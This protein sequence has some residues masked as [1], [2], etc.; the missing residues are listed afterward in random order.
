MAGLLEN[1]LG[2]RVSAAKGAQTQGLLAQDQQ[3]PVG[4]DLSHGIIGGLI[5]HRAQQAQ[6][7]QAQNSASQ[8]R[9]QATA[10]AKQL[11]PDNQQLQLLAAAKPD[12]FFSTLAE[13]LKPQ[14]ASAGSTI[15]NPIAG[16]FTAP[17]QD[18]PSK[19]QLFNTGNG[20]IVS[21]DPETNAATP[22]Y[23]RDLAP[24]PGYRL[25]PDG[26]MAFIPGGPADPRTAGGL[27]TAKRAPPRPA[28]ARPT[29]TGL[30]PGY[31]PR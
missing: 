17:V 29:I 20:D 12:V 31:V 15:R 9:Q 6:I 3:I 24:P 26:S 5:N 19:P 21:V 28:A 23:H 2:S 4:L 18:K 25:N 22:V 16:D 30:P 10:A 13:G 8:Q 14:T 7:D 27:A 1:L 11:F